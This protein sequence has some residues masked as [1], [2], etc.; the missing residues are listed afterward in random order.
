MMKKFFAVLVLILI[1]SVSYALTEEEYNEL[2]KDSAFSAADRE[3]NQALSS[4]RKTL[5]KEDY[6]SL[7]NTQREWVRTGRDEEAEDLID[8]NGYSKARAY[9]VATQNRTA[10][11]R[12]IIDAK[13]KRIPEPGIVKA[14][15]DYVTVIAKGEGANRS[16]ALEA[17]WTEAVRIAVGMIISGRTELNNDELNEK[18]ITHSRGAVENFDI[19]DESAGKT[20]IQVVIQARVHREVLEDVTKTY[21]EAQKVEADTEAVAEVIRQQ[22]NAE[23]KATTVQAKQKSGAE[24]LKELL[25]SYGPENFFSATLDP[26]IKFTKDKKPYIQVN[27]KFNQEVFWKEFI[28]KLHKALEGVAVKKTK[29]FYLDNVRKAN[30]RLPKEGFLLHGGI[31]DVNDWQEG[32]AYYRDIK[33]RKDIMVYLPYYVDEVRRSSKI[34]RVIVPHDNASYTV[35]DMPF[36]RMKG[37]AKYLRDF[38]AESY[39]VPVD[40]STTEEG[41]AMMLSFIQ[42]TQ[43]MCRPVTYAI[44]YLDKSEEVITNQII[45]TG[46]RAF[47]IYRSLNSVQELMSTIL[48]LAPGFVNGDDENPVY[49]INPYD[50]CNLFLG[51]GN[52]N[53]KYP[54]QG[55]EVELDTEELKQ[56]NSMKFEVIFENQ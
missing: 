32:N 9:T 45:R 49:G 12:S 8:M 4:A 16:E 15:K 2:M 40:D 21:T 6:D 25:D 52:Y 33:T 20:G 54:E 19:L 27:E 7:R 56:L 13:T 43:R 1:S 11:I 51:T 47:G 29:Q 28:P 53:K 39:N 14:D 55:Y 26:K 50:K 3:M 42:F 23:A 31:V 30:Q 34:Y 44:S 36:R 18:I 22:E 48:I 10:E 5:P 41:A 37:N 17:S 46:P 38:Y 35:Y 24:L